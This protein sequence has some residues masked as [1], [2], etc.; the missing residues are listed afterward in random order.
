[1]YMKKK[2][3][4]TLEVFVICEVDDENFVY[5]FRK[6]S[7]RSSGIFAYD[8]A[9][10]AF[11]VLKRIKGKPRDYPLYKEGITKLVVAKTVGSLLVEQKE[12]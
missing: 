3:K 4:N 8:T 9:G 5:P 6:K 7:S 11:G 12:K 1:M 10:K 2:I